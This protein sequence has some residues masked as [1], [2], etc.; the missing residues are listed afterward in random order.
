MS[1]IKDK[2]FQDFV[3]LA[4]ET[5]Y[6]ISSE[7]EILKDVLNEYRRSPN[8]GYIIFKNEVEG[9]L[10]GFV[11]FGKV[12]GTVFSWEIYWIVVGKNYQGRRIGKALIKM[13]ED[14]ILNQNETA[15]LRVE[16]SGKS[17]YLKTRDFYLNYGF[18]EVGKIVDFYA[19]G[20]D[21]IILSKKIS[22]IN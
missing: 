20:D 21:L 12:P 16:T 17:S 18:S 9:N 2:D 15:I 8:S 5:D 3:T 7:I 13:V 22:K 4:Q 6:F 1:E 11:I 19:P 14:Y 10:A